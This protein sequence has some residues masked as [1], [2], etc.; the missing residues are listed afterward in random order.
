VPRIENTL[1]PGGSTVSRKLI[2]G[3]AA[4]A[5]LLIVHPARI[6][7]SHN[8]LGFGDRVQVDFGLQRSALSVI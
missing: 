4:A 5:L 6:D 8:P 3:L 1:G 7:L 2:P